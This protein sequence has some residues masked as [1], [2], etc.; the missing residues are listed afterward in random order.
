[1]SV[2]IQALER[3]Y[4][5]MQRLGRSHNKLLRF[6]RVALGMH[7]YPALAAVVEIF[8]A[9]PA[10]EMRAQPDSCQPVCP[11]QMSWKSPITPFILMFL[12]AAKKH[13]ILIGKQ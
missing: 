7:H 12:S 4:R 13:Y 11:R 8:P 2:G 5:A 3:E 6:S 1:M 9:D 10:S